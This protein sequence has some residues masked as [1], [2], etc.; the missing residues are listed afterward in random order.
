M[1]RKWAGL[2]TLGSLF[3]AVVLCFAQ[4]YTLSTGETI[5]GE[6]FHFDAN[7][8]VF[9]Y[10]DG[11]TSARVPWTNFPEAVLKQL[12]A[13]PKAKPFVGQYLDTGEDEG[14]KKPEIKVK[15]PTRL[16]RPATNS[17]FTALFSSPLSIVLLAL[18]YLANIYAGLEIASFRNYP[19]G[20]VCGLA[21]V[22][23]FVAPVIFLCLPTSPKDWG[24]HAEAPATAEE[25]PPPTAPQQHRPPSAPIPAYSAGAQATQT[26]ESPPAEPEPEAAPPPRRPAPAAPR[27][28]AP[29][30]YQRGQTMFNRRFFETKLA[31]F[32]R[33]VPSDAEKDMLVIVKSSRGQFVGLRISK[34]Q[35]SDLVL[36]Y[37]KGDAT[38][39]IT[40]PYTEINEIQVR[41]KDA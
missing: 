26:A 29:V 36:Q 32:L 38:S 23:P 31:G 20:L 8:I 27:L 15:Q 13:N 11:R 5:T 16:E 14:P 37:R 2:I 17:A 22:V 6:P 34:L 12:A 4:S 39:E 3:C 41:H 33:M 35:P 9:K 24:Q 18:V 1:Q 30:V 10:P 19:R 21:A 40:V 7:G 28:P 25:A